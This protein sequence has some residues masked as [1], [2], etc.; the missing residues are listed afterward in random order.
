MPFERAAFGGT[1]PQ[2]QCKNKTEGE[3]QKCLADGHRGLLGEVQ[4][5]YRRQMNEY[6]KLR[7]EGHQ[8]VVNGTMI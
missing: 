1:P 7:Y 3:L 6:H 2:C 8:Q 4:E 5:H